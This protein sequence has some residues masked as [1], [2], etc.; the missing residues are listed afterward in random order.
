MEFYAKLLGLETGLPGLLHKKM[1]TAG[2]VQIR[3]VTSG[4][5]ETLAIAVVN[6]EVSSLPP[7]L[8]DLTDLKGCKQMLS[9]P[10]YCELEPNLAM[11]CILQAL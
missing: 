11:I 2:I 7:E 9:N 8:E 4:R 5:I 10:Q 3:N 6:R 1:G